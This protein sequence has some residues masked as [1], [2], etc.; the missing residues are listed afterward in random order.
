MSAAIAVADRFATSQSWWIA[1]E[2]VRRHPHLELV[3]AFDPVSGGS[4]VVRDKGS[5]FTVQLSAAN[6]IELL[7]SIIYQPLR[8]RDVFAQESPHETVK[9]LEVSMGLGAP[10]SQ[11]ETTPTTLIYRVAAQA[12]ATMVNDRHSWSIV[13]LDPET[14]GLTDSLHTVD[15]RGFP[16]V[17][18]SMCLQFEIAESMGKWA[19]FSRYWSVLRDVGT[20]LILNSD[21]FVH[22]SGEPIDVMALYIARGRNLH[23]TVATVLDAIW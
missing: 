13:N 21:G 16:T 17:L 2:L 9:L 23:E 19:G 11:P 22:T 20:V 7:G 15:V 3:Q 4:L 5:G 1:S 14:Y 10:H 8:W 6:G 12:L 18:E